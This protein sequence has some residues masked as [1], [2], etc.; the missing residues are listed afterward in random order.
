MLGESEYEKFIG[1]KAATEIKTEILKMLP[2]LVNV[3]NFRLMSSKDEKFNCFSWAIQKSE[4]QNEWVD[5]FSPLWPLT[6]EEYQKFEPPASATYVEVA[7]REGFIKVKDPN[8]GELI[9]NNIE[10]I[11][12]FS[13][14]FGDFCHATR[15]LKNGL[16]TS[17]LGI[18][19]VIE[20]P[21]RALEGHVYGKV[22]VIMQRRKI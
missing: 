16:W 14:S 15:Q 10:K 3:K 20:H 1:L 12:L 2:G 8:K 6:E 11:A 21:L 13:N 17:K 7:R 5:R 4:W 19:W 22:V 18:N 9:E